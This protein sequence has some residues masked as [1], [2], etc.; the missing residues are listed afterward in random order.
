[1]NDGRHAGS[2]RRGTGRDE[3][4][5]GKRRLACHDHCLPQVRESCQVVARQLILA[6]SGKI[7]ARFPGTND[8][9]HLATMTRRMFL[10]IALAMATAWL[11]YL[12][13]PA[14]W[15]ERAADRAAI[16]R[17]KDIRKSDHLDLPAIRA[18]LARC[19]AMEAAFRVKW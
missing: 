5:E 15:Q 18:R 10:L 12:T 2:G 13:W 11:A 9:R 17:C 6:R 16:T 4:F 7:A 14:K 8:P 19:D 1:V 3:G